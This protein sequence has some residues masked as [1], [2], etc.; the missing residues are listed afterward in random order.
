[1]KPKIKEAIRK[2][3]E[4]NV[5]T[6]SKPF[7][8]ETYQVAK[9]YVD[10]LITYAYE[11]QQTTLRGFLK[12]HIGKIG[13]RVNDS[14]IPIVVDIQS[15]EDALILGRYLDYFVFQTEHKK[16]VTLIY[17]TNMEV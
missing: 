5:E 16:D 11:K 4:S 17:I 3:Q 10:Q 13:L 1:M 2:I 8:Y 6:I 15:Y 7:N 9:K 12:T 14:G